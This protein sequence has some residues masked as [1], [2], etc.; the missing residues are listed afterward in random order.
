VARWVYGHMVI[1]TLVCLGM[2][3]KQGGPTGVIS[4]F[5]QSFDREIAL[6]VSWDDMEDYSTWTDFF[7]RSESWDM[8]M[9]D[10]S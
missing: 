7:F 1:K 2:S 9:R 6:S 5:S 10:Y 3:V 8:E 4:H